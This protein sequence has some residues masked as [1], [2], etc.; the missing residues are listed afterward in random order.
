VTVNLQVFGCEQ[1]P[2]HS[3]L[4][5]LRC[6]LMARPIV[7]FTPD[8]DTVAMESIRS[9]PNFQ[10]LCRQNGLLEVCGPGYIYRQ[11]LTNFSDGSWPVSF[12]L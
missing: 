5:P 6:L 3:T 2:P 7:H 9:N 8:V 11:V 1:T 12:V 4:A 10:H